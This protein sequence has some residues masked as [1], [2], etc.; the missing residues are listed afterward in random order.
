[1]D[2]AWARSGELCG[3]P[4]LSSEIAQFALVMWIKPL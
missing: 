1:M 3:R 4:I 2:Q